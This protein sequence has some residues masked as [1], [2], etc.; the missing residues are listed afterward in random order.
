MNR[1]TRGKTIIMHINNKH[2]VYLLNIKAYKNKI[3]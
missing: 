3:K 2:E 1:K